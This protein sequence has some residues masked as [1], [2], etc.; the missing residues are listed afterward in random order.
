MDPPVGALVE[1]S[2]GRGIVRFAGA[3]SFS[4]GK[5]IG[6]ELAEPKGKNDGSL[7]GLTYFSCKPNHGVFV[8]PS[9]VKVINAEPEPQPPRTVARTVMS[10]QRTPSTGVSRAASLRSNGASGS[11]SRSSSPVKATPSTS[12]SAIAS[13]RTSRL[14]APSSPAK[15][16][17]SLTLQPRKSFSRQLPAESS[18]PLSPAL[19]TPRI[20]PSSSQE[21]LVQVQR[22]S[23][24]LALPPQNAVVEPPPPPSPVAHTFL[25]PPAPIDSSPS[26]NGTKLAP[27]PS[28]SRVPSHEPTSPITR[29][30]DSAMHA[31][32]R[33][34]EAKR[35]DDARHIREL[36]T[37]LADA[38]S[39]VA[40][41]PKLQ[42]KLQ[43]LQSE[44]IATKRALA[45][46]E[47]LANLGE[48][49][50]ADS[51]EQLEMAM[52][53][54]EVAEE[55]AEL[56]EQELEE[57]K[58]RL[59][60]VEVELGVM[61][62]GGASGGDGDS[63]AKTSLAYIQ[64]E[65]QN[66][67]LKEALIRLRD[68]SQE[69]EQEQRR[70]IA[71]MEKDIT[72]I[73]DLQGQ[74]EQTLIK[75]S[76]AETQI[77]SLQQQLDDALGAEDLLVQLTERNLS[78]SEKIEEQRITIE[79]LEALKELTDEL[80]ENHIQVERELRD[81]ILE[82]E[83]DLREEKVRVGLLEDIVSDADGTIAR[84]R[85]VVADMQGELDSLRSATQTAQH[86]SAT[87]AH[88][89]ATM[90]SLNLKLQSS[91]A[92]NQARAVEL[93][94]K[95]LEARERGE[96]LGIVQPYL[97]QQ[98]VES[99]S[100]ATNCYLFFARLGY[101]TDLINTIVGL[102]HGLPDSLNGVV[103]E[104]LV[105]IC[106]MRGRAASFSTLC[107]R[108]ATILKRCD[109]TSFLNIGR[110]YPEIAPMEKRIDLHI[111]LLRR[112]EFREMEFVTDVLKMLAQF[113]HLAETY[114][115][116]FEQDLGERELGYALSYDHDLD[117]F[118]ASIGLT[119]T[120]V[121][122]ILNDEDV[123]LDM[124]GYDP[125]EELIEPLQKLLEQ[126][127]SAK[128]LS[129]KLTKRLDDVIQE[130]SALK[131]HLLPQLK[132]LSN[133]VP[134]LVNFGI[135]LAQQVIPHLSDARS[136]KAPFQLATVLSYAK[137]TAL[138]TVAKDMKHGTS[139]FEAV[140]EA[141]AQLSAECNKLLPLAME[142][143]SVFKISGTPPWVVRIEEIRASMAINAEA[144]RKA[145][146]LQEEIQ[147][148]VR[149]LKTKDQ[150]IQES[151]VKIEHMERR[152]EAA[153]KQ[154]DAIEDLKIALSTARK[155]ERAYEEAMEQLQADLDTF[156]QDNAKLKVLA[157]G[158][159]RQAAG[160]QPVDSENIPMEG[161]VETSHL[162]EQIEA[163][164][165]TV[166]FLRTENSYLK[167]QDL[168]KEIQALP[169][170]PDPVSRVRTP[171]L[172]PSGQ[173]DTDESDTELP[174]APPTIRSLA[175]ETK[176]LYRDVIKFSS[177]P[178]VVDLS[179]LHAKRAESDCKGGKIWMRRKA[180]PAQQVLDRKME[181]E[182]LSR[183]VRGL[184]DRANAL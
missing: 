97:P 74:Y 121:A 149:S 48:T 140:G 73:D 11:S 118:A 106:E 166:R 129:K 183:R 131:S 96:L 168:L 23:S 146:Q 34:L 27:S 46:A 53:D 78:L 115:D 43:S 164:R 95:K 18:A 107:K 83:K 20:G 88:Q 49:R 151:G 105:G 110:I 44:L 64:L 40:L 157:A 12:A 80:E 102:A 59:A 24:P 22:T 141:I 7:Q 65:K 76:N 3:T 16:I 14:A 109:P 170:L 9:Q 87:A 19:Q 68:M 128:V 29:T 13:A 85:E 61:K 39:F 182:R 143:E 1:V 133:A 5:W 154:A 184:L 135:S 148:L 6:I 130:S 75:L 169:P 71:E 144:E 162:L 172:D 26:L 37:R 181:A 31:K 60:H 10:H 50:G 122:V 173:S 167:G 139:C 66:E 174:P 117:V 36:E 8:R 178:R 32:I 42:A 92:K 91:A 114:F 175:T 150:T 126:C 176:V 177:S 98:Y 55:K 134:E 119:K 15:R 142:P 104:T 4:A 158:S 54:K 86:E 79:D 159:E 81:E 160:A 123:V 84:F 72:S 112:D 90:M 180:T 163:L 35:A 127:K 63:N 108:F 124:G 38:E 41:R 89:T 136:A 77:S 101:K 152:M 56:A 93:E 69:T 99:D 52:L 47:Q 51:Q 132:T 62:E 103:S 120:S 17:P 137:Q 25:Q 67:R 2:A 70:R 161:N 155:Q 147:G 30:E 138:S 57:V 179:A 58:E 82:R 33:V 125:E 45:D 156:E 94:I 113:D 165:G 171:P 111:D 21:A 116:G 28:I 145:A 153:K 100:D